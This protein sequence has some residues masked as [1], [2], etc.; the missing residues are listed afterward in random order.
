MMSTK[1]KLKTIKLTR[2]NIE[3]QGYAKLL[4]K[5]DANTSWVFCKLCAHW[6]HIYCVGLA[7]L[8]EE[9]LEEANFVCRE[10]KS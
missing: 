5:I 10:C 4:Q 8:T 2:M 7:D 9:Q 6:F 1:E 3:L